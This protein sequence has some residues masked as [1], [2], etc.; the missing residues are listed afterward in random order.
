MI[1]PITGKHLQALPAITSLTQYFSALSMSVSSI[2]CCPDV[3]SSQMS[4]IKIEKIFPTPHAAITIT[5]SPRAQ[6]AHKQEAHLQTMIG[7]SMAYTLPINLSHQHGV[8]FGPGLYS[9]LVEISRA[10]G[11]KQCVRQGR[12]QQDGRFA[13]RGPGQAPQPAHHPHHIRVQHC[14]R[15]EAGNGGYGVACVSSHAC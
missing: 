12:L 2:C 11:V 3:L 9:C 14:D 10:L 15:L 13:E 8:Y 1:N 5:I 4:S 6:I 7:C